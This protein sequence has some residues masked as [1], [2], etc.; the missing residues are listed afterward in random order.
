LLNFFFFFSVA[1]SAGLGN[2]NVIDRPQREVKRTT[3]AS[4]PPPP[5]TKVMQLNSPISF[6]VFNDDNFI[7]LILIQPLMAEGPAEGEWEEDAGMGAAAAERRREKA[8]E[9][10][11]AKQLE[12]TATHQKVKNPFLTIE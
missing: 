5:T 2:S 6:S 3:M 4:A 7:L 10:E 1:F 8:L 9:R 12:E 11:K